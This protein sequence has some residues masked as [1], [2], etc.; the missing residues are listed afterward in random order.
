MM[1]EMKAT[2]DV[3]FCELADLLARLLWGYQ[4]SASADIT[5]SPISFVVNV[6]QGRELMFSFQPSLSQWLL[7][8]A[9][10]SNSNQRNP[11]FGW[12]TK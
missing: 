1:R 7:V 4:I 11:A 2:S 9:F 5:A 10:P 12:P 6:P 3:K 8:Q